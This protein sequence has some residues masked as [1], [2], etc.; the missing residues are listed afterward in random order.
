[1]MEPFYKSKC[2]SLRAK[3]ILELANSDLPSNGN[4]YA[5]FEF[6]EE[7]FFKDKGWGTA[8]D[9]PKELS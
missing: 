1:M 5:W 9:R 7:E 2:L 4:A 6:L 3:A 8:Y